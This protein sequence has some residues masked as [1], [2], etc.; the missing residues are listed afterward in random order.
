MFE[1]LIEVESATVPCPAVPPM[2]PGLGF[3]VRD[4]KLFPRDAAPICLFALQSM[5][6]FLT[7]KQRGIAADDWMAR[8]HHSQCPHP[9]HRV[10]WRLEQRPVGT[11]RWLG[12]DV[13]WQSQ[14]VGVVVEDIRGL[15]TSGT[16]IGDAAMVRDGLLYLPQPMCLW[17]VQVSLPALA[18]RTAPCCF[19]SGGGCRGG[20]SKTLVCPD[21]A[22]SVILRIEERS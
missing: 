21:P 20:S 7:A 3:V 12:A 4:E 11:T 8:V 1:I 13:R 2:K 17:A 5:M 22:G 6:P 14:D 16:A 10:A 9:E 19:E 18:A 15:C